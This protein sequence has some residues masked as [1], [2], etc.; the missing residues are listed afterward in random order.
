MLGGRDAWQERRAQG[1]DKL[2]ATTINGLGVMPARGTCNN[3]SD[4]RRMPL[5]HHVGGSGSSAQCAPG[6]RKITR[7][8]DSPRAGAQELQ[9]G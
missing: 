5:L 3:C 2:Y 4:L 1:L 7:S 8:H 6:C 9:S